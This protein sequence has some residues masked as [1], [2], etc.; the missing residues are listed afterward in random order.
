[1]ELDKVFHDIIIPAMA[2]L[3]VAMT[4]DKAT[5][6]L[7]TTGL[8]ESKFIYRY[9]VIGGGKKGPA[10]SFWQGEQGGGMVTGV[11]NHKATRALV[12][13]LCESHGVEPEPHA[14]WLAIENDDI[15]ACALARLLL[16][17][18]PYPLPD[19]NDWAS[20]WDTYMRVWRPGKP[21]PETWP[22]YHRAARELLGLA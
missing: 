16:W 5:I 20:A 3:P 10:R 12:L 8:Q 6:Q 4:G 21:H 11:L 18:D 13:K 1:M 14:I 17:T 15:L 2:E 19:V 7:L 22:G 9:Q